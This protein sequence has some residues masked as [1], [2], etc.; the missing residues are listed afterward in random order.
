MHAVLLVAAQQ[1]PA[2][3]RCLRLALVCFP[4]LFWTTCILPTAPFASGTRQASSWQD[5]TPAKPVRHEIGTQ[6][7][8]SLRLNDH[9]GAGRA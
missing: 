4:R 5:L 9:R 7:I 3:S 6:Q 2:G 8:A 1:S